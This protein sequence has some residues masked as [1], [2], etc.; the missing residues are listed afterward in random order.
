VSHH[1]VCSTCD[2]RHEGLPM[3]YRLE[4]PDLD[5]GTTSFE[6]SRDGEL[7][8]VGEHHFILANLHLPYS[9]DEYFVWTCWVSL[10]G[11]SLARIDA[12]WESKGRENDEPAFGW[13]SNFLPTYEPGTWALKARVHQSAIGIR[14]WIELE[15][16]DH[17][18]A[19]EQREGIADERIAAVYHVFEEH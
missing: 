17:P 18:L 9:D 1:Y 3:S 4:H 7:C 16:T 19:V 10:S 8:T 6:Y 14:P 13:F 11:T 12:H 15:P 5:P 2:E